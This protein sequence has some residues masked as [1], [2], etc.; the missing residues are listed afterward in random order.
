M[1]PAIGAKRRPDH[2]NLVSVLGA[3]QELSVDI[4]TVK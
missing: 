2:L 4:A 3:S 1:L